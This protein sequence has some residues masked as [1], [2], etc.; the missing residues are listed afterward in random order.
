MKT[1]QKIMDALD[2]L[3][4]S[5]ASVHAKFADGTRYCLMQLYKFEAKMEVTHTDVAILGR[6]N[7]GSKPTGWKGTFTGTAY[8]NQSVLRK[9]LLAYKN[10]GV[11]P[12]IDIQVSNEDPTSTAGK[13]TVILK[14]CLFKGG[15]LAKFDASSDN[16]LEEDIEGTFD[17]WEMPE[18]FTL[19]AGMKEGE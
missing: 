11:M 13:Q 15:V 18:E 3:S 19:L 2:A 1:E 7:K 6:S 9:M 4:G 8:Y 10:S 14:G 12:T 17:D 16:P 5:T